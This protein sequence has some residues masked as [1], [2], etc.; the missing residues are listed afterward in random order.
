MPSVR[1]ARVLSEPVDDRLF[2]K[3]K[4][5]DGTTTRWAG[6]EPEASGVPE[7]IAISDS[8][9]GGHATGNTRLK[10]DPRRD[11]P[12]LELVDEIEIYGRSRPL[13]RSAF[14]GQTVQFPSEVGDG[15]SIE[16]NAV[17]NQVLLDENEAWRALYVKAGFDG[18]GTVPLARREQIATGGGS[19]GKIAV[20]VDSG[21]LVWDP[22]SEALAVN[23]TTEVQFSA[24]PGIKIAKLAYRGTRKGDWSKFEAAT[25]FSS[26]VENLSTFESAG[27]TLDS[28][29]RT[30]TLTAARRYLML[31]AAVSSAVTPAAGTQQSYDRL[32]IY[33]DHGL[34][35]REIEGATPGL[36]PHDVLA[37]MLDTGVPELDYK[38]GAD[39]TIIPNTSFAVPDLAFLTPGKVSDAIEKLNAYFLNNWAVWDRKQFHWHPWEPDKLTWRASI[40]G[41][42]Q[43]K[44]AGQQAFTLL[45]GVVVTYTDHA[46]VDRTAGPI[47]SGCDYESALLESTDPSNPYTRRGRRRW[48][49]LQVGFPLAYSSTAFQVG[50]V[51]LLE[52]RMPQRSG[53]LVIRPKGPGH[54]PEVQHPTIGRLPVWAVRSGEYMALD[55]WPDGEAF[56]IIKKDYDAETK[57]L[58]AQLDSGVMRLSGALERTGIRMIGIAT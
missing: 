18:W 1:A 5:A 50:Y 56:R 9:P 51:Y 32:A 40:A 38:V 8:A 11:W 58:T 49:V 19:Q 25:V 52:S 4:H 36:Y 17:G 12:D 57:S 10:R 23:E 33:G 37:H 55:G 29:I 20:S 31:R 2:V 46:G 47:G 30:L 22:P 27:L 6:D 54:I 41:G 42:A 24:P 26:D 35:L 53:T 15:V 43:W 3:L 39:G 34:T 48:G 13:G 28:T 45:N 7:G 21:G 16:V 44:P 14:E